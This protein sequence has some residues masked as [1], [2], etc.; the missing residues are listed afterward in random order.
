M[1]RSNHF[2]KSIRDTLEEMTIKAL[3]YNTEKYDYLNLHT[4]IVSL[5]DYKENFL[6]ISFD[7]EI[8]SFNEDSAS[9]V[10]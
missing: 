3:D 8:I 5:T 7:S 2:G 9:S 1:A 4:K 6:K 10:N